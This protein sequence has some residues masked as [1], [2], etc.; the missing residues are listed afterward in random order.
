[1][2]DRISLVAQDPPCFPLMKRLVFCDPYTLNQIP[3]S[4]GLLSPVA[5]ERL[6]AGNQASNKPPPPAFSSKQ[7]QGTRD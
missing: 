3:S 7:A 4:Q 5:A 1:M 2:S 6:V